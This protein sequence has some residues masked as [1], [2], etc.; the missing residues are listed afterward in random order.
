MS[1]RRLQE[2]REVSRGI[3]SFHRQYRR[4]SGWKISE[5]PIGRRKWLVSRSR[6]FAGTLI[7]KILSI[8]A[9]SYIAP[10]NIA[11]SIDTKSRKPF[12]KRMFLFFQFFISIHLSKRNHVDSGGGGGGGGGGGCQLF[13]RNLITRHFTTFLASGVLQMSFFSYHIA[14]VATP[15]E[16]LC[17]HESKT[18]VTPWQWS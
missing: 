16:N 4:S 12:P 17:L 13:R 2:P 1:S 6:G 10:F 15:D 9:A 11:L 8:V 3:S 7:G 5:K 18:V 14:K